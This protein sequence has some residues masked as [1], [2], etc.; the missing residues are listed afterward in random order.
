MS[1]TEG[2]RRATAHQEP[3]HAATAAILG[4]VFKRMSIEPADG[5]EGSVT[6]QTGE[7]L[8]GLRATDITFL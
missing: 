1:A 7:L 4:G 3:D 6:E 8:D 5:S 2:R